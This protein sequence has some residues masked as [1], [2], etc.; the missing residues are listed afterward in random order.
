MG[1]KATEA[2]EELTYDFRPHLDRSG[3][4][5]EP[6]TKQIE[7]FRTALFDTF[8][9]SGIDPSTLGA[10]MDLSSIGD[11]MEKASTVEEAMVGAVADLTGIA[12][13]DLN[14]LPYRIKAAF[15]G[16]IMGQFFNPEA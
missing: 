3:A 4:I 10:K 2:V 5:P 1:F 11:L 12:D 16:W 15:V 13:R 14:A 8:Q 6:S 9:A 7:K